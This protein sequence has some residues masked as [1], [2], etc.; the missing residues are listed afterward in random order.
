MIL[1]NTGELIWFGL[2]RITTSMIYD[3][4]VQRYRGEPV[5]TWME[6]SAPGGF[7]AGHFVIA[8]TAYERIAEFQVGNGFDGG[9][10]H[11]FVLTPRDTALVIVYSTIEWDL[12]AVG[13]PMHGT[14]TDGVIQELEIDTGRVLFEWHTL[15]HIP[16]E[17]TRIVYGG[18]DNDDRPFDYVHVNSIEEEPDNVIPRRTLPMSRAVMSSPR[19]MGMTEKKTISARLCRMAS[20]RAGSR[21]IST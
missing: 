4:K 3:F 13:G 9:D 15:D 12:S 16:P 20:Y 21:K 14:V 7:G 6:G 18:L 8:N 5:L 17:E 19:P 1:D 2:P 10:L 11:E